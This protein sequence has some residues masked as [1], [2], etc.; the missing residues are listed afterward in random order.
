MKKLDEKYWKIIK[1]V[2]LGVG[3]SY[4][5]L[6]LVKL[7]F[8]LLFDIP[9]T[10]SVVSGAFGSTFKI[11]A[12][13][14]FGLVFAY[15][16]DPIVEFFQNKYE[17]FEEKHFKER[18]EKKRKKLEA[19]GIVIVHKK[20]MAG[21]AILYLIIII[22]LGILITLILNSINISNDKDVPISTYV[23]NTIS[24]TAIYISQ[25]NDTI[26]QKLIDIGV[27]SYFLSVVQTIFDWVKSFTSSFITLIIGFAQGV[28]TS[29]IGLVMGF[30]LLVD[31][32]AFKEG[33]LRV[34]RVFIPEK[35]NKEILNFFTRL[36]N[37]FSGY[38]RGQLMDATIYGTLI[39]I[40]LTILGVPY[41]P[42]IGFVSG[43]C[44]LIPYVGAFVAFTLSITIALFSGTPML[45]VYSALAVFLLQQFDSVYIYPKCVA[46]NID[47]SPLLVILAL[48]VGGS[49]FGVVG[50]LFAVPITSLIKL[51]LCEFVDT[52][53]K[54]SKIKTFLSKKR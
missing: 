15:L 11:L 14:I 48:S 21:T 44:N 51:L 7:G 47:I 46:S 43:F 31:K 42:F 36:H 25:M 1:Y 20:R 26:Q 9:K 4:C 39:G 49:L 50:M 35:A 16:F 5:T 45:A 40:T 8:D 41:A 10:L 54:N 28:F 12:P 34:M 53:E 22:L 3:L 30:Y 18:K 52:Q 27:S 19:K 29:F 37:I 6:I 13:F 38:I 33:T 32:N 23:V 24:S 17:E 2:V